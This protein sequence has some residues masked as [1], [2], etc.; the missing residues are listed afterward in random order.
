MLTVDKVGLFEFKKKEHSNF[1]IY[2]RENP[3]V[4]DQWMQ[5]TLKA[6]YILFLQPLPVC[7]KK[8]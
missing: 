7:N 3:I 4:Y 2:K 8:L 5:D 1:F 6:M